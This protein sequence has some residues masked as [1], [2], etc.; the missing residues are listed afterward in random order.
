M[1]KVESKLCTLKSIIDNDK[2][3]NIPRYQRLFVWEDEQVKTLFNDILTA[4]RSKKELYYIGGIITV[5]YPKIDNC[6]DLV[7]GQQRFT[8]LWLLANELGAELESFT[9]VNGDLRLNFSIRK[10]VEDYLNHLLV[11]TTSEEGSK[12]FDDLVRISKARNTLRSLITE[13]LRNPDDKKSFIEFVLNKLQMVI[14]QVPPSSDLNKLFETLNNRGVQLSQHE[15]LKARLLSKIDNKNQRYRYSLIWNA[16]SDMDNYLERSISY[17]VGSAKE[18][19]NSYDYWTTQKHNWQ[20][21]TDLLKGK[22][23][24]KNKLLSLQD[25]L[26]KRGSFIEEGVNGTN[27]E[28]FHPNA[29]DDEFEKVRSILTFPQLLLHTLRIYLF[30]NDKKD[31]QRINGKEL[32]S[33]FSNHIFCEKYTN[34]DKKVKMQRK[35]SI[36]FIELLLRVREVFDKYVIKWVEENENNETHLIKKVYKHN[37]KKG[38]RSWYLRRQ[39]IKEFDG[40]ALLQ[41]VLYHSQQNTTQYW[42]TPFLYYLLDHPSFKDAYID[43]KKT[44]NILFSSNQEHRG[45]PKRTMECMD[46]YPAIKPTTEILNESFGTNFPHYWFYKMEF[47]LWHER[48]KLDKAEEWG[49]YKMTARNSV[50]HISPQNPRDPKDKL[51]I[52]ELDNFGNLVLVTRSINSEYS[53]LAYIE[54]RAKFENKKS[55]GR[56]DSLKSDLIYGH[57]GWND[58]I[59]KK[60][61]GNMITLME[62]Y[63]NIVNNE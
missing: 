54:K 56:L 37:Q 36:A 57:R 29:S 34:E 42:L 13:N 3:F 47:V 25:I 55:S 8:T 28:F 50:E 32:L 39:K 61:Q 22:K 44:D 38:G 27:D 9:R 48:D 40:L 63:F 18:V 59:S 43:L 5:E 12:E 26:N 7:D 16:C 1:D 46:D 19:A 30:Q 24:K 35:E 51:C 53:D 41:S 49:D 52:T 10:N 6:Y 11:E 60:H 15:I 20:K 62:S 21:V 58:N 31:I 14:T 33:I 17:E 4:T 45:L 2:R 23:T